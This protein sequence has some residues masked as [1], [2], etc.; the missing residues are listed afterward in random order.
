LQFGRTIVPPPIY[1]PDIRY[2]IQDFKCALYRE[3]GQSLPR[4]CVPPRVLQGFGRTIVPPPIYIPDI[5]YPIQDFKCALYRVYGQSLPR[6]CVP[7]ASF[8]GVWADNR[9][10][11]NLHPGQSLPLF[12]QRPTQLFCLR[13]IIMI[14]IIV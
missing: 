7:P 12:C 13:T 10:P 5:R 9:S 14:Y 3:Y 11:V 1:I 2:P 8:A 4:T 6:T